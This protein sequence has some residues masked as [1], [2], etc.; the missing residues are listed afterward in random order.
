M[1]PQ[2][3]A[4]PTPPLR[5]RSLMFAEL[6]SGLPGEFPSFMSR[7]PAKP[8]A[9]RERHELSHFVMAPNRGAKPLRF[10]PRRHSRGARVI[11]RLAK[12]AE[13]SHWRSN[14][15]A[16]YCALTSERTLFNACVIEI[17]TVRSLARPRPDS[18]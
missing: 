6:F 8:K 4:K 18:G 9:A 1:F 13:G 2:A 5:S 10:W 3:A 16:K 15:T 11:P 12:R 17:A 7:P 14:T